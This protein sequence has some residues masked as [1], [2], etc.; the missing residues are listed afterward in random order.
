MTMMDAQMQDERERDATEREAQVLGRRGPVSRF[1][2][3]LASWRQKKKKKE[4]A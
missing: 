3:G 1:L 4:K 2:A